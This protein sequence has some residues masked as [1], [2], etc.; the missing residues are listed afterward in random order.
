MSPSTP[1]KGASP[2]VPRHP[3]QACRVA[4]PSAHSG[5]PA[6]SAHAGPGPVRPAA[7]WPPLAAGSR[8]PRF[9]TAIA[10]TLATATASLLPALA[11]AAPRPRLLDYPAILTAIRSG[12]GLPVSTSRLLVGHPVMLNLQPVG[13]GWQVRASDRVYFMCEPGTRF[14]EGRVHASI[15][16]FS[17]TEEGG[18]PLIWLD[19]CRTTS[20]D[21]LAPGETL[22]SPQGNGEGEDP[23]ATARAD[24]DSAA[25][26]VVPPRVVQ[27]LPTRTRR[28]PGSPDGSTLLLAH[29]GNREARPHFLSATQADVEG[30][31][32]NRLTPAGPV[33]VL[34]PADGP[35]IALA[36]ARQPATTLT[37]ALSEAERSRS[38]LRV[39]G[40]MGQLPDGSLVF[41]TTRALRLDLVR[42]GQ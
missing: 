39:R 23:E 42:D 17:F 10:V 38:R 35:A 40:L 34:V 16:R 9:V 29:P 13:N 14:V 5:H 28:P 37:L 6:V 3:R 33:F 1:P 8:A 30:R 32:Q 21:S 12:S 22:R 36:P 20:A 4:A 25:P 27:P 11:Q 15:A 18:R 24:A 26:L 31:V 19:R 41:D 2:A 7:P